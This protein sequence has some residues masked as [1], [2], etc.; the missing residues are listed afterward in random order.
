M[1]SGFM[2]ARPVYSHYRGQLG[3]TTTYVSREG[4]S[5]TVYASPE[6]AN[7]A[8]PERIGPVVL[9]GGSNLRVEWRDYT[10]GGPWPQVAR[11]ITRGWVVT[12]VEV[13]L[14]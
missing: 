8:H 5:P 3:H 4:E 11:S 7:A 14:P 9:V 12:G 2:F 13:V 6:A 1:A 10:E